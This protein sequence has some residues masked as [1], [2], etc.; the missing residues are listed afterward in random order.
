[1]TLLVALSACGSLSVNNARPEPRPVAAKADTSPAVT[2]WKTGM[3]NTPA[4]AV[5]AGAVYE[6]SFWNPGLSAK[7]YTAQTLVWAINPATGERTGKFCQAEVYSSTGGGP[8]PCNDGSVLV[9]N[10]PQSMWGKF[11]GRHKTVNEAVVWGSGATWHDAMSL[12]KS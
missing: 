8:V 3:L 11:R 4:A 7:G 1:M 2:P 9:M 12:W 5:I 10:L 6:G